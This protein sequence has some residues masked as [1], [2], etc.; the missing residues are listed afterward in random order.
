[1]REDTSL[2]EKKVSAESGFI[3]DNRKRQRRRYTGLAESQKKGE[4]VRKERQLLTEGLRKA[5]KLC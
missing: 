3:A 5:G 1:M 4:E 2:K